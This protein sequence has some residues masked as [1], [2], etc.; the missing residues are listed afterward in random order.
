MK[1]TNKK[2]GRLITFMG[3]PSSGKSTLASQVHTELK[4]LGKNSVFVGEAA[5]D[6]IA[7]CG[8]PHTPSDQLVIFYKQ[9]E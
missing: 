6:F 5:T 7:E 4:K 9:L 3:A 8:K 2:K 1:D